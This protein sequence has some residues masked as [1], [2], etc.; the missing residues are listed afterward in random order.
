MI[1]EI[2]IQK[3]AAPALRGITLKVKLYAEQPQWSSLTDNFSKKPGRRNK[4]H[5]KEAEGFNTY[6]DLN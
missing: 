2:H 3:K 4:C 5:T 1:Q 6:S